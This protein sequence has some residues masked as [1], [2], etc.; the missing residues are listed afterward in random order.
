MVDCSY[1]TLTIHE[2]ADL[3]WSSLVEF[4]IAFLGFTSHRR[5]IGHMA[6]SRLNWWMEDLRA[7]FQ[8]RTG[9]LVEPTTFR[10]PRFRFLEQA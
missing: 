7:L 5:S 10:E 2:S 3:F 6:I 4:R 8:A 1:F 9:T